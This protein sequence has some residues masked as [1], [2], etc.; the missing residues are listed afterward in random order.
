M[1]QTV[2]HFLFPALIVAFF[3]DY[4]LRSKAKRDFPLHYVLIA[5]VGG[6][7]PDFDFALYFILKPFGF[8][9]TDVHRTITHSLVFVALLVVLGALLYHL[10][11]RALSKHRLK[12]STICWL[13][14]F[15]SLTHI[16]LDGLVS[17]ETIKLFYPFSDFILW[18][19]FLKSVSNDFRGLFA[20]VL[21][22]VLLL[23]WII[24]LELKHK[25]SDFI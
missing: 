11:I 8:A 4:Y 22:G 17:G 1:P 21:D 10:R 13:L 16:F 5:G 15:G 23:A 25:I 24:Y 2:A 6:V 19:G 3:R 7:L 9:L 18:N 20:P 14:A 12:L